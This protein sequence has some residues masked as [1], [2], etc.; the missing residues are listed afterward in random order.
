[1][2]KPNYPQII[3]SFAY[4]GCKVEIDRD[5]LDEGYC[6]Y[7]AWVNHDRGC[8]VAVPSAMTTRDAI[9]QAK[10]WIDRRY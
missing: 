5:E 3:L 1:M 6:S 10:S 8:A 2:M 7:A 9:R 4:R